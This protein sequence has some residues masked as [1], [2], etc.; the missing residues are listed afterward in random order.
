MNRADPAKV[1]GD[2]SIIIA[3][4]F[5]LGYLCLYPM[6]TGSFVIYWYPYWSSTA[7]IA[8]IAGGVLLQAGLCLYWRNDVTN[9]SLGAQVLA[10]FGY[11]VLSSMAGG[12]YQS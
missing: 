6:L 12:P 11:L 5:S 10:G 7:A 8:Y 1:R 9:R 2:V 3:A 4:L